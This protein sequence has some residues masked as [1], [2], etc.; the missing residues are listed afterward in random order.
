M[1]HGV[2][3]V[4]RF[5]GKPRFTAEY[6]GW[7]RIGFMHEVFPDAQFVH[8]IRDGRAVVNS[9]LHV[10]WWRGY[11]GVHRWQFGLPTPEEQELLARHGDSFVARAGIH[12][13][14]LV[15]SIVTAAVALDRQT[16]RVVRYEDMVADPVGITLDTLTWAGLPTDRP[17]LERRLDAVPI[18]D[19][20]TSAG[21]IPSWRENLSSD[22]IA[23]LDDML[24][25]ELRRFDYYSVEW[26]VRAEAS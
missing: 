22:Q 19:A 17:W 4:M 26:P 18:F 5:Q 11:E 24:G 8:V 12:W 16:Y 25:D 2:A 10:G 20:N 23:V 15:Q 3:D 6:S 13:R 9:F 7:S 21:R 14:R 1:R